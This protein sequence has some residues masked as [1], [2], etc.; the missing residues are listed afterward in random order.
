[1]RAFAHPKT[2]ALYLEWS[3]RDA[4]GTLQ[5]RREPLVGASQDEAKAAADRKAVGLLQAAT[6]PTRAPLTLGVLFDTYVKEVSPRTKSL[7]Y[8]ERA[9]AL[10]IACW[11]RDRLARTLSPRDVANYV[12]AR[13]KGKIAPAKRTGKGVRN[14]VLEQDVTLLN[15]IMNWAVLA[16]DGEG[17]TLLA[18]NPVRGSEIPREKSVR[19]R[20]L[21]NGEYEA[22]MTSAQSEWPML[23]LA[24]ELCHET[25]HRLSS[26]RQ[27]RWEDVDLVSAKLTW[28]GE[29]DK[30]GNEHET[31]LTGPAI[32]A[33]QRAHA[34]AGK[35]TQGWVFPAARREQPLSRHMFYKWWAR[36]AVKAELPKGTGAF[37]KFRR[38]L[39]SELALAPL[40][41]VQALGGWKDPKT[42]VGI[43]QTASLA[44]QRDALVQYRPHLQAE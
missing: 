44:Q 33:L 22:M 12:D 19:R 16:G 27:V 29:R 35:P 4:E 26:V 7:A 41:V 25:G 42:V 30:E 34:A 10:F 32:A 28:A 1:V 9:T 2:G 6:P 11:G 5:S 24:V 14:R 20:R 36:A 15:T 23:A 43:Y 18:H 38:K 8:H 17:G 37:H 21:A 3:V 31:A 40:A 39:A 13:R